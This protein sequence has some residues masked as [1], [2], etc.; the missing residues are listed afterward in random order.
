M[1]LSEAGD[2]AKQLLDLQEQMMV[3]LEDLNA[4]ALGRNSL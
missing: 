4:I 1:T 3:I 2:D